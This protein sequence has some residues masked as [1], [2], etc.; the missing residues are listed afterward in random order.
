MARLVRMEVLQLFRL[1]PQLAFAVV[2]MDGLE[3]TVNKFL[4]ALLV[5]MDMCVRMVVPQQNKQQRTLAIAAVSMG[6][7]EK[8]VKLGRRPVQLVLMDSNVKMEVLHSFQQL[9]T[10][11]IVVVLAGTQEQ[12]AKLRRLVL[13]VP[14]DRHA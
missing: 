7:L 11:V 6:I 1:N 2:Q 8:I 10:L 13:E 4:I 12:I 3:P 5:A 14:M 9:K